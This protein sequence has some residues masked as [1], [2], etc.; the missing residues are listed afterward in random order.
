MLDVDVISLDLDDTLWP[1]AP[2]IRNAESEMRAWI[3]THYPNVFK[4]LG[5]DEIKAIRRSVAAAHPSLLHDLTFLRKAVLARM[6]TLAGYD[7][8]MVEPAFEVFDA[9]RNRVTFFDGAMETLAALS[10]RYQIIGCSNGNA[11]LNRIGV[12]AYFSGHVSA[13]TAG[14][15]KPD[16][17]VFSQVATVAGTPASRI[18]HIGDDLEADVRGALASGMQA[19]WIAGDA[20]M[21][22]HPGVS[23]VA[24][25]ADLRSGGILDI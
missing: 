25:F 1:V 22:A 9:A 14:A 13:K 15:A 7:T 5:A 6:A 3:N 4:M 20:I 18:A 12:G 19:I 8:E 24:R 17:R 23:S 16:P 21:E 2:V 11:D 10:E